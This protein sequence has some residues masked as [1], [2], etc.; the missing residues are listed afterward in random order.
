L[1][2]ETLEK[3]RDT[4]VSAAVNKWDIVAGKLFPF[5]LD[6]RKATSDFVAPQLHFTSFWALIPNVLLAILFA[7]ICPRRSTKMKT[8]TSLFA[9]IFGVVGAIALLLQWRTDD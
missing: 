9:L 1:K 6:F 8:F 7:F 4:Y 2:T 5:Y 3:V